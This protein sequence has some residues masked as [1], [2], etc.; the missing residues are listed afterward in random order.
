MAE[1]IFDMAWVGKDWAGRPI[2][3]F[4]DFIVGDVL[5]E[6][7]FDVE[8]HLHR[9][10][11]RVELMFEVAEQRGFHHETGKFQTRSILKCLAEIVKDFIERFGDRNMAIFF[12]GSFR[13]K[14]YENLGKRCAR[15]RVYRLAMKRMKVPGFDAYD[16][17]QEL[18]IVGEEYEGFHVKWDS[19]ECALV[20]DPNSPHYTPD[21]KI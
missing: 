12:S 20:P 18:A 9:K 17:G 3:V 10:N 2:N 8:V 14:D 15:D 11:P 5:Y 7:C 16:N 1:Y 13:D 4:Y 6:A 19:E 21:M